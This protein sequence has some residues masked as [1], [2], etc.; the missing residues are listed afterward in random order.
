MNVTY[1]HMIAP[2]APGTVSSLMLGVAW[3]VG[4]M[5]VPLIGLV[6]DRL[7]LADAGSCSRYCLPLPRH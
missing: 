7:G 6:G 1:A 3:G 2:V 5:A 4:G